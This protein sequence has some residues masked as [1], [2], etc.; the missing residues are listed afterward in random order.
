[1]RI[2]NW[3]RWLLFFPG[4]LLALTV[5]YAAVLIGNSLFEIGFK[6]PFIEY[7]YVVIAAGA[8]A[9]SFVWCGAKIAPNH[10][11]NISIIMTV[12]YGFFAGFVVVSK[13]FMGN[14]TSV[15]WF[16]A[17]AMAIAGIIGAISACNKFHEEATKL[18]DQLDSSGL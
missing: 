10:H 2:P 7:I 6:L 17:L 11:F 8:S 15:T 9:Y 1:M 18:P 13:L 4:G 3:L 16:E 5:V 14:N 12:I